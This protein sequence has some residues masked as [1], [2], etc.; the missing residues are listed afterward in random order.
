MAK[1]FYSRRALVFAVLWTLLLSF[2]FAKVEVQIEGAAGWAANLPTWRVEHHW[3][4]DLFW[5]GRPMTGYHAW[6][7]PCMA[8]F[9]HFPL[10]LDAQW[11]WR[12]EA[13][14]IGCIML[15]WVSEDFLWFAL[16]PAFGLGHFAPQW[17][18]WHKHWWGPAPTD[19]WVY[20]AVSLLMFCLSCR[21]SRTRPL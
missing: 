20:L 16:N 15:F 12:T 1:G 11:S 3:L 6:V 10:A 13:R 4:L 8:L 9:F 21:P 2:F 17:V 14:I 7:F 5:G 18:P 19:Y